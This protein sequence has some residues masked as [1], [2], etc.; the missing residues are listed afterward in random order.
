MMQGDFSMGMYLNPGNSG[1][2]DICN[3]R[4]VDKTGLIALI[5]ET[6]GTPDK[7]TCV[8]R[9]RRFGKSY[10]AQ[11][12]CAYY[13][14]TCQ[15]GKLFEGYQIASADSYKDHL[16]RYDVIYLDMTN[17]LGKTRP[18]QL[19]EFITRS[20]IRE[21]KKAYPE[22]PEAEGED[23]SGALDEA[24]VH[25]VEYTGN[26]FIMIIDEWDAPIRETPVIE[27]EYLQFLR[28]LF[29]GSGT[30]SK[31]FAAV[32]M[33]G[34]LP[35]KKDGS[36]SAIS[37]FN[38]YTMLG[39]LQFAEY[40]G[41]TEQEVQELCAHYHCDFEKMKEWYDG[42]SLEDIGSIYNPNSVMKA[43]RSKRFLSYWTA[44]SAAESLSWYISRDVQ[45]L[46]RTIAELIGGI[47]V[48]VDING[49][50]NDLTTFRNRDDVLTLLIHLGYLAYDVC[51]GKAHI[52][53]EEIRL[54]F[55]R[56]IHEDKRPAT[57]KRVAES[58]RLIMDTIHMDE[59][60]VA[61]QIEKVHLEATNPLNANNENSLRAVVQ[62][63]YFSYRDYY[64]KMEELPTGRGYVDIV[65]LPKQ[66]ETVPALV[67]ELKW[68][69]SSDTA[70]RQIKDKNYPLVLR[71]YGGEILLVGINYD[72]DASAGQ[73]K[74]SCR[75]EK[76]SFHAE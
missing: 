50:A 29:K 1:F 46:G 68:N 76:C 3:G 30:T 72:K 14:K 55:A 12:L 54:E 38:E 21:L 60:A 42:Y 7:L 71:D 57:M 16:N 17:I 69:H 41:F 66:G 45:G 8:S 48:P 15:S 59:E 22:Y 4:Y 18:E 43:V 36:Q 11:M 74:Y 49:F 65:Y 73:R 64:L 51:T 20:V 61:A 56:I 75:I 32:Y 31:I 19:T 35:I 13:D 40:V 33:T 37:D 25:A 53:N 24:L 34:I 47:E 28:M 58:D 70:I 67:V 10:A 39:P 2:S 23:L 44:T 62:L 5:N 26:K 52:P 63:A 27:K 6:I 9:P